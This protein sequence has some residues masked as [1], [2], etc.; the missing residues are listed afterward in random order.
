M[1]EAHSEIGELTSTVEALA[2]SLKRLRSR[3]GMRDLR[4]RRREASAPPPVPERETK[5]QARARIFGTA[6]GPEFVKRQ[7]ALEGQPPQSERH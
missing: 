5:Q 6:A 7:L 1:R 4:E 3:E 2:E